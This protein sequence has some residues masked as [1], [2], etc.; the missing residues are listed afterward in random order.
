MGPAA[1]VS[2]AERTRILS[3]SSGRIG[4]PVGVVLAGG[5]GRRLRAGGAAASAGVVTS[6]GAV[7]LAGRPL[8]TYPLGALAGVCDRLAVVCKRETALPEIAP[9]ERWDEPDEPRHPLIG[10]VHA[11]ERARSPVLVCA[12]DMPFVTPDALRALLAAAGTP[13]PVAV[14]AATARG[15]EPVLAMY[16]PGALPDLRAAVP[17]E[18]LRAT[19]AG[20]DPVRVPVAGDVARSVN[21]PVDLASAEAELAARRASRRLDPACPHPADGDGLGPGSAGTL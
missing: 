2:A 8:V 19:V 10:I 15:I 11:L 20:L 13:E 6:K 12:A 16:R 18:P 1:G 21:T 17:G 7:P 4:A 3:V 14:V 9:A 5:A